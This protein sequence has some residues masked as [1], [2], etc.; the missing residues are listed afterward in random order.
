[1]PPS[2]FYSFESTGLSPPWLFILR[3][4]IIFG[5]V[6]NGIVFLISLSAASLL[7]YRNAVGALGWLSQLSIRLWLRS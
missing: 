3:Y 1:M 4:F 7:V 2:V 5:A 6:V